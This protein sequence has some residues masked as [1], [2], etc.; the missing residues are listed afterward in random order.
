[1]PIW[2]EQPQGLPSPRK[3]FSLSRRQ[4]GHRQINTYK[5]Q[6][7]RVFLCQ[8]GRSNLKG[9][10]LLERHLVFLVGRVAIGK[11]YILFYKLKI[12]C[13]WQATPQGCFHF[14]RLIL[15]LENLGRRQITT[16]KTQKIN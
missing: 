6:K 7:T 1:M 12:I 8:F 13:L 15:R 16:I 11:F 3:T 10:P 9:C 5:L 14:L 4:S 2:P